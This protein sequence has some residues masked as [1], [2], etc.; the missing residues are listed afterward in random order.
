MVLEVKMFD[1]DNS[2]DE[3]LDHIN[4]YN[5]ILTSYEVAYQYDKELGLI[6]NLLVTTMKVDP[7]TRI[8]ESNQT[9]AIEL[10]HSTNSLNSVLSNPAT[11]LIKIH[12]I[13]DGSS[14][15]YV[16]DYLITV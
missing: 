2:Q 13:P 12:K 16:V 3:I 5:H 8:E 10:H 1:M 7:M 9:R 4:S 15:S 14:F 6:V 11:Q